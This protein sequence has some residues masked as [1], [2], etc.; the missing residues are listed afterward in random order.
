MRWP[1][2][3]LEEKKRGPRVASS[4][5]AQKGDSMKSSVQSLT[6]TAIDGVALVDAKVSVGH[7]DPFP[8]PRLDGRCPFS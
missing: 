1:D 5:R 7:F 4:A 3:D 8:P 2:A 6:L